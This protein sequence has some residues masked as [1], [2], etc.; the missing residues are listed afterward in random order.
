MQ[1]MVAKMDSHSSCKT[2]MNRKP[3]LLGLIASVLL[4]SACASNGVRMLTPGMVTSNASAV[5]VYGVGVEG[6]WQAERFGIDLAAYD[7]E[8]QSVAGSCF[9]FN[10]TQATVAATPGPVQYFAFEVP[11]GNYVYIP[12]HGGARAQAFAAPGGR[13]VYIGDF[14]Y[15]K[16]KDV[17]LRR[18]LDS[19]QKSRAAWLPDLKGQISLAVATPVETVRVFTCS[20]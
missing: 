1:N 12:R 6:N 15:E 20:L 2:R 16:N 5:V 11:A 7:V 18:E 17:A 10:R 14:V 4:L 13:I 9:R 3:Y 19:L 8:S